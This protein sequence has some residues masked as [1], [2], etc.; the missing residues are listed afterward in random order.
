M[1]FPFIFESNFEGGT[2]G[3]WDSETDTVS[4]LDFPDH[5]ELARFPW[6]TAA[7]SSG[8]HCMRAVLSGG[9]ADAFVTEG[10]I[11]IADTATS[12]FKFDVWFSPDFAATADDTF[13]LFELVGSAITG[14]IGAKITA[15]TDAIQ[16][17][18]GSAATGTAPSQ[19]M[20]NAI[21]KGVWYTV[22]GAFNIE[23]N[24]S[25]TAALYVTK[26]GE[27]SR[28]TADASLASVTN[29]AVTSGT[30]G[31]QD[32]LATTTGTILYDN[33]VQ[34]DARVYPRTELFPRTKLLTKSDNVFVGHGHIDRLELLSGAGTDNVLTVYDTD[35]ANIAD[36]SNI[37]AE[38]KNTANSELVTAEIHE[39]PLHLDRGCSIV[40][41]G[42]NPRALVRVVKAPSY[43][44]FAAM[45]N[46][47]LK[48]RSA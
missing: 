39:E 35:D 26:I 17:G 24:A 32:H 16:L 28:E 33:F 40:L 12:Y 19:F 38:L 30:F 46:H 36:K 3:E 21:D 2:S 8:A 22:E 42:T 20:A 45:R 5:H 29:V 34:D 15:T 4:Q 47:G 11:N 10:D 44:S 7:P 48:T 6:A 25:G 31:L 41:A 43:G 14:S 1:S 13:A 37:V 27:R 9:T 18:I 23:T